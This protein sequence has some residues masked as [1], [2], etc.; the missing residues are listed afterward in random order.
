MKLKLNSP[1]TPKNSTFYL[2]YRGNYYVRDLTDLL[3]EPNIS[4]SDF[5]YT[6]FMT[7]LIVVV[8]IVTCDEFEK[9]YFTISDYVV[10][11][12]AKRLNVP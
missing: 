5:N 3:V 8:P 4:A 12:S 10:P 1:K 9:G 11:R 7:T 6:K 2:L